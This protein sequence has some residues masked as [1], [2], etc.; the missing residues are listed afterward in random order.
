M[1]FES[2]SKERL[3]YKS[4]GF[5]LDRSLDLFPIW[6]PAGCYGEKKML[7]IAVALK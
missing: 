2:G 4:W 7:I 1:A 3:Y 6:S 5:T